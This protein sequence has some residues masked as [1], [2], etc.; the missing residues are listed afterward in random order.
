MPPQHK[1][2][3]PDLPP[4]SLRSSAFFYFGFFPIVILL[5]AWTD[6]VKNHT[7][8]F[9]RL[10]GERSLGFILENSTL[11]AELVSIRPGDTGPPMSHLPF[12]GRSYRFGAKMTDADGKPMPLFPPF[13]WHS[14]EEE[15]PPRFVVRTF[16]VPLWLILTSFLPLWLGVSYRRAHRKRRDFLANLPA[17]PAGQPQDG[18]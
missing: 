10:A 4:L 2:A 5:W 11:R 8:W 6:S 18:A 7:N 9:H 16:T 3:P 15:R 14:S 17:L 13:L 1:N 12:Y